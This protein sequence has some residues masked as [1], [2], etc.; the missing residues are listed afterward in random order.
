MK[1][2]YIAPHIEVIH[3]TAEDLILTSKINC[4]ES[5]SGPDVF[6]KEREYGTSIWDG[7]N[8]E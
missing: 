8:D 6:S 3:F 4:D 5:K 7:M 2:Q 1:K